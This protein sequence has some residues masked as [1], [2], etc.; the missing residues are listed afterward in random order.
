[1][2]YWA[3][4]HNDMKNSRGFTVVG[5]DRSQGNGWGHIAS[6]LPT[7]IGKILYVPIMN[8]AV[9]AIDWNAPKLDE[10][11]LVSINDLG[12]AGEAWNRASLSFSDGRLY[13]HTI[14]GIICIE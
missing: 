2:N 8:G 9:F 1:V 10:T 4:K 3:L 5:D 13:A 14:K 6:Q 12:P 11:A 7:A